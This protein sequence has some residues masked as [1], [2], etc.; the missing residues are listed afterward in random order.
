MTY[1][2]IESPTQTGAD[3]K[4]QQNSGE[5]W[6]RSPNSSI[7]PMV[8][9]YRNGLPSRLRGIEFDTPTSPTPG[10]RTPYEARRYPN[11]PGVALRTV[12]GIDFAVISVVVTKNTQV[13]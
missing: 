10:C 12:F 5:I 1:H 4:L 3:A 7:F 2:R 9:A 6:G 13:P 11:T 8:L